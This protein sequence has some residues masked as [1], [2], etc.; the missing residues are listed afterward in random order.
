MTEIKKM[1]L[2]LDLDDVVAQGNY[3]NLAIISHSTSEFI[4]DFAVV[5]PGAPKARVKSRVILTPEH[6]KR[7]LMSL[8]DNITRYESNMGKIEIPQPQQPDNMGPKIGEA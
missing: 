4:I 7:L 8:Q 3:S 6:A 5:L 2:E 1:G